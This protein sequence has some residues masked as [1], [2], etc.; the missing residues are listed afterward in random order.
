MYIRKKI[1]DKKMLWKY[2]FE[3]KIIF[4]YSKKKI[5]RKFNKAYYNF[6]KVWK[7]TIWKKTLQ[8]LKL[9]TKEMKN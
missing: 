2:K 3:K 7:K 6:I 8:K 1:N 9:N 5:K 4:I